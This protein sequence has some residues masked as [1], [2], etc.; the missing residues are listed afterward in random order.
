M[1][2][3]FPEYN[4][5]LPPELV[6]HEP[7][8]VR[9]NARLFVYDTRTDEI[10]HDVFLNLAE[11]VPH[12]SVLVLNDTKVVPA[13]LRG[14]ARNPQTKKMRA[15]ELLCLINEPCDELGNTHAL[16]HNKL[17]SGTVVYRDRDGQ[18]TLVRIYGKSGEKYRIGPVHAG[19]TMHA[20]LEVVG[21][22][23]LPPYVE[24]PLTET[25][26]RTRYQTVFAQKGTSVAAPTASLHFT[27]EVFGA[28]AAKNIDTYCAT[29]N[30]GMGTFAQVRPEQLETGTLHHEWYDIPHDT[31]AALRSAKNSARPVVAVGTTVVR[32]LES[33]ALN[34]LD[35]TD[36]VTHISG[37]TELFIRPRY[38]FKLVDHLI[39]N[40]HVPRSSLMSLVD[41]FLVH[42]GSKRRILELYREAIRE[43]Y[44]FYSFGDSMLIL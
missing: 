38:Q 20:L 39:T 36:H 11:H 37:S 42:K 33:A 12:S 32:T 9:H 27:D 17:S 15:V 26:T 41:A 28:L 29:L 4:Y 16:S 2:D 8:T 10:R 22:T 21:E 5:V 30:V 13:R 24:T 1:E 35:Y 44:R 3:I 31:C 18:M 7:A 25:E 43:K 40:F 34:I 19:Q 6:A 23:P 14:F